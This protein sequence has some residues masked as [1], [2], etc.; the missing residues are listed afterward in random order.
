MLIPFL[1]A[2]TAD[3]QK[4]TA[5][6]EADGLLRR[7]RAPADAPYNS[8]DLLRAFEL[9]AFSFE[10][11]PFRTG[12]PETGERPEII[13]KVLQGPDV[14]VVNDD[15]RARAKLANRTRAYLDRL[16][17]ITGLDPVLFTDPA[18]FADARG[19]RTRVLLLQAN[20][21]E[22]RRLGNPVTLDS[23][24]AQAGRGAIW[25]SG[26]VERWRQSRSPCGGRIVVSDGSR[27][28]RPKGEI[29]FAILMIR[30]P[31]PD[32]LLESCIEEELAQV[33]GLLNDDPSLRPSIFNDD[34]E[35]A[36][37]T[38]HDA[39]LLSLLYDPQ[40][41]P[42]MGKAE[43]LEIIRTLLAEQPAGSSG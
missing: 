16:A 17:G 5:D 37:L 8:E 4:Y 15:T 34:A 18:A 31:I 33:L 10:T 42:G 19:D 29:L 24:F 21:A 11:D 41:R 13:R 14:L 20:E 38:D 2:C 43:A 30:E 9:I 23:V 40:I 25:F 28:D 39:A 3:W 35:F 7:E 32:L 27:P 1:A 12:V 36:L 6:A 22:Y 26:T